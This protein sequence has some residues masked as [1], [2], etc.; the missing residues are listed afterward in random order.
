MITNIKADR[1]FL[2]DPAATYLMKVMINGEPS[3]SDLKNAIITAV[4]KHD[5]LNS[6][7]LFDAAGE[8]YYVPSEGVT[9][10]DIEVFDRILS[11]KE[12]VNRAAKRR[13]DLQHGEMVRFIICQEE[14][15][16]EMTAIIHHIA[17]DG[18]SLLILIQDIMNELQ[19]PSE[20]CEKKNRDVKV[21]DEEYVSQ[22]VELS[23]FLESVIEDTNKK[24]QEEEVIFDYDDYK[25]SF[26]EYWSDKTIN[27]DSF[28]LKDDEL[29]EVLLL[30]KRHGVTLNNLIITL[31]KQ[32]LG[33]SKKMAVVA[34]TREKG[35]GSMGNYAEMVLTEEAYDY[36][37]NFWENVNYTDKFVKEQIKDRKQLL[38]STLIRNKVAAGINDAVNIHSYQSKLVEEYKDSLY[39]GKEGLPVMLSNIGVAPIK[40]AYG[41]YSIENI[42]FVSPLCTDTHCNVAVITIN[43]TF[44]LNM[45]TYEG[46]H[47]YE[48]ILKDVREGMCELIKAE[49]GFESKF[50]YM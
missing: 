36:T 18:K 8:A 3:I 24:W 40:Q 42:L 13:F 19:N 33:E 43:N 49:A 16:V 4:S 31:I 34:D 9:I 23:P 12:I 38:L 25:E 5:I 27:A 2:F 37:K 15:K 29:K 21:V 6:K 39:V 26:E 14:D 20:I 10:P 44:I 46:E 50:V 11:H 1:H 47:T 17:G 45:I 41:Q 22:F 35:N 30:C 32:S 28:T 48:N 7:I